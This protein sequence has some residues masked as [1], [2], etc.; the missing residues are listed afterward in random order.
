MNNFGIT[1]RI[2]NYYSNNTTTVA[3]V[4]FKNSSYPK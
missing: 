4:N 1:L 2:P 3:K